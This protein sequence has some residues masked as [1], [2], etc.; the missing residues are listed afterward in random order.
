MLV[1]RSLLTGDDLRCCGCIRVSPEVCLNGVISPPICAFCCCLLLPEYRQFERTIGEL[2]CLVDGPDLD[3][4]L[5]NTI[6]PP[7]RARSAVLQPYFSLPPRLVVAPV[8]WSPRPDVPPSYHRA[9]LFLRFWVLGLL[10]E[11]N[12][13]LRIILRVGG[14]IHFLTL[15]NLL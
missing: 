3:L 5:G 7:I 13:V 4:G 6:S 15:I 14:R 12:K 8:G 11:D 10:E 2:Y 9:A 1:D